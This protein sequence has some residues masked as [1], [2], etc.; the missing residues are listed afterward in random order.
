LLF[1]TTIEKSGKGKGYLPEAF[2]TKK[3]SKPGPERG[4][5][6]KSESMP[7]KYRSKPNPECRYNPI[8]HPMPV[9]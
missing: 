8:N 3:A 9:K 5:Q 7:D 4:R 2:D 1:K 6:R